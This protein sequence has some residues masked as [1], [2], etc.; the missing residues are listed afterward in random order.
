MSNAS[1][2]LVAEA[3]ALPPVSPEAA[4]GYRGAGDVLVRAVDDALAARRDLG[5]LLG[6][7][8]LEVMRANHRNH[9]RFLSTV[10]RLGDF[11][12]LAR[13][14]PWV[15]RAYRAHGFSYDYF[16]VELRAWAMALEARLPPDHGAALLPAYRWMLRAHPATVEAAESVAAGPLPLRPP[17]EPEVGRL[18]DCLLDGRTR[19]CVA[20]AEAACRTQHDLRNVYQKLLQPALYEVGRRWEAG[21]ISVAEE[22]LATA[23]A[24]RMM[25]ALYGRL[26]PP[27]R[28]RRLRA[29][30]TC[31][32]NEHHE[33][34]ARM[35]ADLLELE[36]WDVRYLGAD[37]PAGDVL[38][39]LESWLPRVLCLSVCVPY[40]LEAAADLVTAVRGD[41]VLRATK[42]LVGGLAFAW[43]TA[44]WQRL[45]ADAYAPDAGAAADVVRAWFPS[46]ERP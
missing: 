11:E 38:A 22:H 9:H 25:T 39:L 26:T 34:G 29:V 45:G 7:N 28:A 40:N 16:P 18:V 31:A 23:V 1:E 44:L 19:D 33:V 46:V 3:L 2:A 10:L 21:E 32:P 17:R 41:P 27:A 20:L 13:I 4:A 8:P 37:T 35:V 42:I 36:G 15:Y 5:D 43:S 30:V 12:L 14:L 6:G 24:G